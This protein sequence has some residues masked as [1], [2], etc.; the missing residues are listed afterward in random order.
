MRTSGRRYSLALV[1]GVA[2][3][4]SAAATTIVPLSTDQMV[5]ASDLVIRGDVVE[6]WTER[7]DAGR[8]WTRAQ[9][10]VDRVFKGDAE[11]DALV[12]EQ[13][14]GTWGGRTLHVDGVARFA[15]GEEIVAFLERN[16]SGRLVTVAM[17]LG[18]YT[19]RQDPY[20]RGEIAQR[21]APPL[22]REYD[23]RFLPLP[24]EADRL[25][26]AD[27]EAAI[28]ARVR[29]GWDGEPIPGTSLERLARVNGRPAEVK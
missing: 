12:V 16:P 25:P 15:V 26:V 10:E 11:L 27:L 3:S 29:A 9:V 19:V 20:T 18:K 22:E 13:I 7:D 8:V 1:A 5:D 23:P 21:Y 6:V 17:M 14:G 24:A 28:A 2:L 4:G